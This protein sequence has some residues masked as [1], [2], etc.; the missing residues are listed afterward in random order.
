METS[1]VLVKPVNLK[2]IR[3]FAVGNAGL[4]VVEPLVN[5]VLQPSAFIAVNAD[6]V[7][8]ASSSA[9]EKILIENP[10]M[11]GLGIGGDPERGRAA[12]EEQ[13]PRFKSFAEGASLVVIVAGL[14]GASG[15]GISPVV[16]R[17][18]R[19]SGALVLAFAI[20][21]FDCEG[22][23]RQEFAEAGLRQLRKN[24]DL[25]VCL[26]NQKTVTLLGENISV[27][28]TFKASN[29]VL[30]HALRGVFQA[31]DQDCAMGLP[32]LELCRLIS[33][34]S[35]D[36]LYALVETSGPDRAQVAVEKLVVHPML[37]GQAGLAQAEA[38]AVCVMG[39]PSLSMGE[40]NKTMEEINRRCA[41][42]PV[43]M[44][45]C[46]S[47]SMQDCLSL[48]VLVAR[49]Q[50]ET[51]QSDPADNPKAL[52]E[53]LVGQLLE[54]QESPRPGSRFVPPAPDLPPEKMRQITTRQLPGARSRKSSVKLRQGQ[55]PL[56]IVSK[57]RFDK[58]EPTIHKGEDLDVPTYIRRGISLN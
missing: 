26:S 55:L 3:I 25:V 48:A 29:Q 40:V 45:A 27:A 28:E 13:F 20:L 54:H 32:F 12:A 36:C 23:L 7:S 50:R 14:G 44:G 11:R 24:A 17:A 21:P 47:P 2:T 9:P 10:Q 43:I 5:A 19:E 33:Q 6:S 35:A 58:S 57:G 30:A 37:D 39:G 38:L 22:S 8:L 53:G 56:E 51:M 1:P 31:M 4:N 34:R 41:G 16:A 52:S 49:S 15:T 42:I 18:A 46:V